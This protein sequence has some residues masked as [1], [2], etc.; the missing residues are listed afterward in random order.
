ML[1]KFWCPGCDDLH[2]VSDAWQVSGAGPTLTIQP[3]VLVYEHKK[4]ID[5]D[6]EGHDLLA[7]WNITM[8]P[9][10][11]S[12]VRNG[13]IEYLSDSTH[14]LAGQTVALPPLPEWCA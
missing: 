8:A 4:L 11:H 2:M 5:E 12:F 6:L 9:R 1:T 13:H 3:S 14:R 10:C 7:P